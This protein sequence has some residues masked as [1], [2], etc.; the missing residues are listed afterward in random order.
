[1]YDFRE[2]TTA[3]SE[4]EKAVED[5]K[6][7]DKYYFEYHSLVKY[8]T[9][10]STLA[11]LILLSGCTDIRRDFIMYLSTAKTKLTKC[12]SAHII[13]LLIQEIVIRSG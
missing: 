12:D 5:Q 9:R 7:E 11:T 13:F 10:N 8:Y 2:V 1:M 3:I 4:A 6:N